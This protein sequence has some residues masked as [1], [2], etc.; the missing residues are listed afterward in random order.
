[1]QQRIG[2]VVEGAFAAVTPGAFTPTP[3]V[4]IPPRID[5]LALATGALEWTIFPPERVDIGV[6]CI[7]VEAQVQGVVAAY[8]EFL[9]NNSSIKDIGSMS[10]CRLDDQYPHE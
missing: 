9:W 1:V 7:G 8:G 5:I 4:V 6:A 3:V 10:S 2:Q